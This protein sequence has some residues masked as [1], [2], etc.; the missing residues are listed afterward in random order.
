MRTRKNQKVTRII[1]VQIY[2]DYEV[3]L[4][5]YGQINDIIIVLSQ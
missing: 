1:G 5:M 4:F 2:G 3:F